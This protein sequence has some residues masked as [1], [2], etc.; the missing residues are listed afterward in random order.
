M[1]AYSLRIIFLVIAL[2]L[3]DL[4]VLNGLKGIK[5]WKFTQTRK[6]VRLYWLFSAFLLADLFFVVFVKMG[7]M[8][9]ILLITFFFLI[10]LFKITYLPVLVIDDVRR[11][12]IYIKNRF[13]SKGVLNTPPPADRLPD[14]K[15]APDTTLHDSSPNHNTI[16][17][18]EFL[19]KAGLLAGAIPLAA[20]KVTMKSGCYDYHVIRQDIYLPNLPKAFDGIRLGQISDIH[21]GSFFNKKAVLGGVEMLMREKADFIFFT[22]D[23]VNA[24]TSEVKDYLDIFSK[25]KAPLG[26]Y[27]CLGN[28]DYGDYAWW[29]NAQAKQ[30]NL[31]ELIGAH[32]TM[33]YDLLM[34]E[35]RRLKIGN[36]EIGILGIENWGELSR[37][38]KYGRMDLA[39]KN[40]DDLPVKLLLSHDPSHWRAQVLPEYPQIDMMFSGHT[41][42]MQM[43]VRT[44]RFQW[45]PVEYIYNEWAGH[46]QQ[47]KQQ[48]YV[49]VG[50]GFLNF[51]G[52][53]GILPEIT[54]FTLKAGSPPRVKE[55]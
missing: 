16:P 46:Y 55:S 21:S 23:L 25:V 2:L 50:Y 29:P 34:N 10:F 12:I 5:K 40:T 28:H 49:N 47:G 52:R 54:I 35:H 39:V 8:G 27:S 42:G 32:K 30:K 4:Y 14:D 37:F 6:F 9:R 24:V 41:H 36:E 15:G 31:Q 45:S 43:G 53:I 19:M 11:I 20:I 18:S 17:R 22:G 3:I 1:T 33:G 51:A 38:P 48:L 13:D 26:V 44:E 7:V